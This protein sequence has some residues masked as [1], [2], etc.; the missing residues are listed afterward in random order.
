[1]AKTIKFTYEDKDYTLEFSRRSVR[2]LEQSGFVA[3]DIAD[4]PMSTIPLLFA[5]AFKMHHRNVKQDLIDEI[6]SHF[7]NKELLLDKLSDMYMDTL[8]TLFEEKENDSK[9]VEWKAD[10]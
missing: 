6:Y 3:R 10:F 7:S 1:M 2:E 5:G 9:N 4:K 8:E